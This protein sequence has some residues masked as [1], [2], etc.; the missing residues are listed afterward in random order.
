M[1]DE[2]RDRL[3][4]LGA[5]DEEVAR[6][7]AQGW[8]PLLTLDQL[9]IPAT[10]E[11]DVA[12]VSER[13]GAHPEVLRRLWRA[14]GFPDVP[15]GLRVF[16]DRDVEAARTLLGGQFATAQDLTS[17]LRD[18][19]VISAAMARVASVI[20]DYVGERVQEARIAGSDDE[21]TALGLL[22]GFDLAELE[23]LVDYELR[24]QLRASL[25]RR[26]ALDA[27]PELKIAIGF[28]DLSG[29]TELSAELESV[30]LGRLVA[31]W[32]AVSYDTVIRSG[33][34]VVKTIGDEVMFAGL[35]HQVADAGLALVDEVAAV[36]L[37]A[38]RVGIAA[39]MVIPR[40]GDYYGPVVNLASRLTGEA[41]NGEVLAPAAI[42]GELPAE[43]FRCVPAGVRSLRGIGPVET[44]TVQPVR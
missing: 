28:A 18:V 25:W 32:E 21:L 40:G 9:L 3:L 33:A 42:G 27:A 44:V 26:L 38:V 39:G 10:R 36:D 16:T 1:R 30:E 6:A 20:S 31:A 4:A 22:D 24:L 37:P 8:V 13:V 7:E 43:R 2:L 41:A 5:T 23:S 35:A 11:Y 17:L 19:R 34:R 15:D 12:D 14:V 29:Y